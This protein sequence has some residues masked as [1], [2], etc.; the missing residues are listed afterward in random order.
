MR[1]D[2]DPF[3]PSEEPFA[4]T[5]VRRIVG[6]T[7]VFSVLFTMAVAG[8]PFIRFAYRSPS[9]HVALDT[10]VGLIALL[11][12]Y[13]V[14]GRFLLSRSWRDLVLTASLLILG[15]T[16][17]I[18]STLP[19]IVFENRQ[20]FF[21]WGVA[22]GRLA[23][24][25]LFA[26]SAITRDRMIPVKKHVSAWTLIAVSLVVPLAI[27][28]VLSLFQLDP[29][30]SPTLSPNSSNRPLLM[31]HPLLLGVQLAAMCLY[32]SAAVGLA[33]RARETHDELLLWLAAGAAMSAFA[34]L[35][36]F[37]FPSIY[38][39]WVYTGD[40]LRIGAHVLFLVGA[41]REIRNYWTR[42]GQLAVAEERRRLARDL[43]DG[44]AQELALIGSWAQHLEGTERVGGRD[45]RKEILSASQR[46]LAEARSAISA[47]SARDIEELGVALAKIA[48]A[49]AARH[50]APVKVHVE[51]GIRVP[52]ATTEMLTR[53]TGEAVANAARH[54]RPQTIAVDLTKE[55]DAIRL[56]VADDGCGFDPERASSGGGFG[57]I[58]MR[59]R[60]ESLGARLTI[61]SRP[62]AG[63]VVEVS[64]SP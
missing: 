31:G 35:N 27:A 37:L 9:L 48:T 24:A 2:L 28:F 7:A 60:A 12:G 16:N 56:R 5:R 42:V 41:G 40:F 62:Q 54:G 49:V 34:R 11:A 46:A 8:I 58:S 30:I 20:G 38:S 15:I 26:F 22:C 29:G 23:G 63:T 1:S 14:Y 19:S 6:A 45:P 55:R 43:H 59:E 21:I 25:V 17:L 57:L 3:A 61:D 47:L 53:I 32:G 51:K 33:R 44:V 10:A 52:L 18:L 13:L 36:Y 50:D 4:A 64:I 39:D